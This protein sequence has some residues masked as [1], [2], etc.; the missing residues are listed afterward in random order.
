[1][2]DVVHLA[3]VHP[4]NASPRGGGRPFDCEQILWCTA[5]HPILSGLPI[6]PV[7]TVRLRAPCDSCFATARSTMNCGSSTGSAVSPLLATGD[8]S[9]PGKAVAMTGRQPFDAARAS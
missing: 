8:H 3:A 4:S 2:Q 6:G 9:R 1:M 5:L 7:S